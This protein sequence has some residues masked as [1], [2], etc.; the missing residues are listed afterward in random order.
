MGTEAEQCEDAVCLNDVSVCISNNICPV[1]HMTRSGLVAP[2]RAL[3]EHLKRSKDKQHVM[4][5]EQ[6]YKNYFH[7][8]GDMSS[9]AVT[10]ADVIKSVQT[11]FGEEWAKKCEQV[12]YVQLT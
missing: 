2:R 7:H 1:C 4:W 6:H 5:R 10:A 9:R 12:L 3:Q 8:G 11:T